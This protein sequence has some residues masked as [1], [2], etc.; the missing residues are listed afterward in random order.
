MKKL[1]FIIA[2][3]LTFAGL[4]PCF[5]ETADYN[6]ITLTY[7]TAQNTEHVNYLAAA[8]LGRRLEEKSGGKVKIHIYHSGEL[9]Q[10]NDEMTQMVQMGTLDLVLNRPSGYANCGVAAVGILSLPFLFRDVDHAYAVID[11]PIGQEILDT[12]TDAKVG[13]VG[14]GFMMEP[15]ARNVYAQKPI[16][17]IADMKGV[18][19]RVTPGSITEATWSAIGAIPCP[20]AWGDTYNSLQTG[21]CNAAENNI[22][23]YYN[24]QHH[25]LCPYYCYTNHELSP[26]ILV[27][28]EITKNRLNDAT[29]QLI[30][31]TWKEVDIEYYRPLCLENQEKQRE[32]MI[33]EGVTEIIIS[34]P[35][36]WLAAVQPIYEQYG[37]GFEKLI[38]DIQNVK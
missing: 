31:D 8:E 11:S 23:G 24:T 10:S 15:C 22:A 19:I 7:G 4:L 26:N 37:K 2:L 29:W 27:I 1:A 21:V 12:I 30:Q 34:D 32:A 36:A 6:Q 28:S 33:A 9:S 3:V 5:A 38:E 16:N 14:L 35:E 18:K 20:I 13:L 17:T 25:T